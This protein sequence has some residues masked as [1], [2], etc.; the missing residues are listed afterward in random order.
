MKV[1][2]SGAAA[3]E[4]SRRWHSYLP[5]LFTGWTQDCAFEFTAFHT[6]VL[7]ISSEIFTTKG[8]D[9]ELH[10]KMQKNTQM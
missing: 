7:A 2:Q 4:D 9:S 8:S 1:M 10:A 3:L 5:L 6:A